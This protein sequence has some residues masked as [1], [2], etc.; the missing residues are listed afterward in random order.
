MMDGPTN[1]VT[2]K[3]QVLAIGKESC[4]K[5]CDIE[6]VEPESNSPKVSL[7]VSCNASMKDTPGGA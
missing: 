2:P 1:N 4:L 7:C 6:T 3:K 5:S